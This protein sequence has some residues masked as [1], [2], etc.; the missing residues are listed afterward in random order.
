MQGVGGPGTPAASIMLKDTAVSARA[1]G[2]TADTTPSAITITA[3]SLVL[4]NED[5]PN[6]RGGGAATLLTTSL[7]RAPAGNIALNVGTLRVNVNPDGTPI[8]GARRVF[9]N[10]PSASEETTASQAGT[11]TISG[12][13]QESNDPAHAVDFYNTQISTAVLGGT[14]ALA[15][16]TITITADTMTMTGRTEIFAFTFGPAPAGNLFF[17]VNSLRANVNPDGSLI[18]DGQPR[19]LLES[20]SFGTDHTAGKAGTVTISGL[21]PESTDSAK[22]IALNNA[23]ISTIVRGGTTATSPATVIITAHTLSVTNSP[24]IHTDTSGG[25][26]AGNLAL[27]V[28][29]LTA[30]Q[31]S[32]IR[33]GT[34]G[35]GHGGNVSID[36]FQSVTLNNGSSITA[37]STGSGNAGNVS[38]N[39]GA[40]FLSQNASVTTEASQASGGNIGVQA[41]D[42][43]RLVNSKL[44]TSVQGGPDT[45]GG[46]ITIDPTFMTL[47]N[48]QILAQAVQGQGGNINIVAGNFLM[49]PTSVVSASSQFGLSGAVN[50]QSPVSMLSGTLATL[51]QRPLQVQH[52]LQQRCA[53]QANGQL[54]S[55]VVAGRDTLPSEPGGWLMS[56]MALLAEDGPVSQPSPLTS[57]DLLPFPQ[58]MIVS[59]QLYER[60]P[61]SPQQSVTNW[62]AGC[63]S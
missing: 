40:Q 24:H 18:N 6:E 43:V 23:E 34:S 21:G 30:D 33:S 61:P 50:I 42:S 4:T 13:G 28:N 52:L 37:S 7:G 19:S 48:S 17:N 15:P 22:L 58:T 10:S 54:S 47:Q 12:L 5:F 36:A 35:A 27:H 9:L 3:D 25:A 32:E 29:N 14:A 44:S 51:P 60:R 20:N 38:I 55:L 46:N 41:T 53:A 16:G 49:D 31:A 26:P 59:G 62:T 56:S 11:I 2:G 1:F 8:A 45:S 57:N 63:G 39:A